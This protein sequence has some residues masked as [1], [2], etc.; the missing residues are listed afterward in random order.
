MR[1]GVGV[2]GRGKKKIKLW[3]IQILFLGIVILQCKYTIMNIL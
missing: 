1:A 3:L 2:G